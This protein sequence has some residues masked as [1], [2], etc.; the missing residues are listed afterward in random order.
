MT[1]FRI[2]TSADG[3]TMRA[4]PLTDVANAFMR[5]LFLSSN[6]VGTGRVPDAIETP[7]TGALL[8]ALLR[9]NGFSV[10]E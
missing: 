3:N 6:V 2:E 7:G 8:R 5:K 4:V 9:A 10:E 1:D